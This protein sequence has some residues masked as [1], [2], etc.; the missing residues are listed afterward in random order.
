MQEETG[1]GSAAGTN[2]H[3]GGTSTSQLYSGVAALAC[4]GNP[5]LP[6]CRPL[7]AQ[8]S[9]VQMP[10]H[11]LVVGPYM[12]KAVPVLLDASEEGTC[13]RVDCTKGGSAMHAPHA[14]RATVG[15]RLWG[16][17]HP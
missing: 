6:G 12:P 1:T 7:P 17:C 4:H 14:V 5:E 9:D 2:A 16:A 3:A 8:D 15:S 13:R 10:L 11:Q